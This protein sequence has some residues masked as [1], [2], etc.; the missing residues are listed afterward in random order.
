MIYSAIMIN[1]KKKFVTG[2]HPFL[3]NNQKPTENGLQK[4]TPRMINIEPGNDAL[5]DDFPLPRGPVFSGSGC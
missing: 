4:D 2:F 1:G 5:E 3:V